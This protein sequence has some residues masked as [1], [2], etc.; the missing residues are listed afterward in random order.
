MRKL[1][2]LYT[3]FFYTG[4]FPK[5]SGTVATAAFLPFYYFIFA[6]MPAWLYIF[7]TIVIILTG[8]WASNY[9]VEIFNS[10]D[11]S[12]VVIDEVAGFLVTMMFIPLTPER[13][14]LGFFL[15]RFYD[16]LKLPP[17][18][19]AER[20]RGGTGIMLDDIVAGVQ[21]NITLWIIIFLQLDTAGVELI[22]NV[23]FS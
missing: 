13:M 20:L 19:Q 23:F 21:A 16:I 9:A 7:F 4:Y 5:G 14:V 6:G 2:I 3:S 8:I 10:K 17:A 18:R 11:P 22:R 12:K 15:S 1:I